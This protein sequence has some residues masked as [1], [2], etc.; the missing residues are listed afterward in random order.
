MGRSLPVP[1]EPA[2]PACLVSVA[3]DGPAGGMAVPQPWALQLCFAERPLIARPP[4]VPRPGERRS[5]RPTPCPALRPSASVLV[6]AARG[7]L[8]TCWSH[9]GHSG[10]RAVVAFS[11]GAVRPAPGEH[12]ILVLSAG[13]PG[14]RGRGRAVGVPGDRGDCV[15]LLSFVLPCWDGSCV[16]LLSSLTHQPVLLMAQLLCGCSRCRGRAGR[17]GLVGRGGGGPESQGEAGDGQG[18]WGVHLYGRA[19]TL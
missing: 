10:V 14:G 16:P 9:A 11:W 4:W 7:E 17:R 18:G 6:T 1:R 19:P 13:V 12:T 5:C 15:G 8:G 3:A 2:M